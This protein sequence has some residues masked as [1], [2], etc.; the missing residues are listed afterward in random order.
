MGWE[1]CI[2]RAGLEL[3]PTQRRLDAHPGYACQSRLAT[4]RNGPKRH[5][6]FGLIVSNF[7]A[8]KQHPNNKLILA[9]N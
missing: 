8:L 4:S 6:N 2:Q 3:N 5:A 1:F 9:V 7:V